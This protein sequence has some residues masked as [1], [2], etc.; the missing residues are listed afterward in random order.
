MVIYVKRSEVDRS[1]LS[2]MM[3]QY[4]EIKDKYEDT[5]I[6][7]YPGY[8]WKAVNALIT[9]FHL[10]KSTLIMLVSSLAGKENIMHAMKWE[11]WNVWAKWYELHSTHPMISK[12][13]KAIK[14]FTEF[15][16]GFKIA[17]RDLEIR[18][19]G[20]LL[21]EIQHGHLEQVGYDTYCNLL[22]EVVKEIQ[23]EVVTPEIDV[24]IDLD[25]T[26][27]IPDFYISDSDYLI[28]PSSASLSAQSFRSNFSRVSRVGIPVSTSQPIMV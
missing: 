26:S 17:M 21:G 23:G 3:Q 27:Y 9:N 20:S 13:L 18:G 14:E 5:I 24:Q 25:V 6:F 22:D 2:P 28:R 11:M 1:K 4:M 7:I 12:R 15:G 19:A 16:S 10:P 8:E